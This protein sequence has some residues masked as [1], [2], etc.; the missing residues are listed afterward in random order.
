MQKQVEFVLQEDE[1]LPHPHQLHKKKKMRNTRSELRKR[2]KRVLNVNE[3]KRDG[4]GQRKAQQPQ[5]EV[6]KT[7]E[8]HIG[9]DGASQMEKSE[10]LWA[11]FQSEVGTRPKDCTAASQSQTAQMEAGLM[12]LPLGSRVNKDPKLAGVS[13]TEVFDFAGE[14]VWVSKK[15]S[16]DS[17]EAKSYL[18]NWSYKTKER[19]D[20]GW[21]LPGQSSKRPAG[22]LRVL[23]DTGGK[24]AKMSSLEKSRLDWDAFKSEEGIAEELAI[25]N[26]GRGG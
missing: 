5:E 16:A 23:G 24:K 2:R 10:E 15:V 26:R 6:E 11:S 19:D 13:I 9:A 1:G 8:G 4:N 25:D 21:S 7:S 22:I 14:K 20:K 12:S 18:R 17:R 3:Q